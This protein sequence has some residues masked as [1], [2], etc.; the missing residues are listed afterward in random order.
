[1]GVSCS[2]CR[3]RY[4]VHDEAPAD[5]APAAA[6]EEAVPAD[7]ELTCQ[8]PSI[9]CFWNGSGYLVETRQW[10]ATGEALT[11][12]EGRSIRRTYSTDM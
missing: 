7:D 12:R 9:R 5:E 1:M 8:N 6:R 3:R 2:S 10:N 4:A 11:P